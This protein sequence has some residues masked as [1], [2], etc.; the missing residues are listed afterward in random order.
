MYI[1]LIFT[2]DYFSGRYREFL[3][4]IPIENLPNVH[5]LREESIS[6]KAVEEEES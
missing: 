6:L 3:F 1:I 4:K 2:G 5:H